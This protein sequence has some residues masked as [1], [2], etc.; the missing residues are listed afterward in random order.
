MKKKSISL[1][2][3]YIV[4]DIFILLLCSCGSNKELAYQY[5]PPTK[6]EEIIDEHL[7]NNNIEALIE[8][9][10][11]YPDYS[12]NISNYLLYEIDYS[13]FDYSLLLRYQRLSKH[14]SILSSGY[15]SLIAQK[16]KHIL[17]MISEMTLQDIAS[18]YKNKTL[19]QSFLRPVLCDAFTRIIDTLQYA[20]IKTIFKTFSTTDIGDSIAP[21]YMEARKAIKPKITKSYNEYCT[22]EKEVRDY[23]LEKT[24]EEL[25]YYV[26]NCIEKFIEN[27]FSDDLPRKKEK[28]NGRFNESFEK[29]FSKKQMSF[30][31]NKNIKEMTSII[32]SGRYSIMEGLSEK[33]V[34]SSWYY[35]H[36]KGSYINNEYS[37]SLDIADLYKIS[38]IQN[39]VDWLGITLGT[40]SLF[41]G[42][43]AGLALSVLD[44]YHGVKDVKGK[45]AE[46]L[47][48]MRSFITKTQ[49][50]LEDMSN[51]YIS[52]GYKTYDS[53]RSK[54]SNT[55]KDKIYE[56]Y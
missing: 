18:Y 55:F 40:V 2:I 45:A 37:N 17:S 39:R 4:L 15:E 27:L 12:F 47:P 50:Y 43:W 9:C 38:E 41:V 52:I 56:V 19:E 22:I 53:E 48:Y 29:N 31:V 8:D 23:Y 32:N 35:V 26:A 42:G 46:A 51:Y 7:V 13:D 36:Y 1:Y 44:V 21:Y 34:D 3:K 16:E 10:I 33:I 54:S 28:I 11:N 24:K 5:H 25:D 14:D 6:E 20:E 30:I 49:K